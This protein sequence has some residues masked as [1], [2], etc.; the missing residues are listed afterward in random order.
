MDTKFLNKMRQHHQRNEAKAPKFLNEANFHKM[1]YGKNIFRLLT[2]K[3]DPESVGVLNFKHHSGKF[4]F[5]ISEGTFSLNCA[6]KLHGG[7]CPMCALHAELDRE[8]DP[9]AKKCNSKPSYFF[10]AV[11]YDVDDKGKK[12]PSSGRVGILTAPSTVYSQI[13]K[14][15]FNAAEDDIDILDPTSGR[16][17][18]ITKTKTGNRT[19]YFVQPAMRSTKDVIAL[20]AKTIDCNVFNK[21][22][23]WN[24]SLE[25]L[26]E[27]AKDLM[28]ELGIQTPDDADVAYGNSIQ[29]TEADSEEPE[30]E[31]T[32]EE[33][34]EATF[35]TEDQEEPEEETSNIAV[36][37]A[38]VSIRERMAAFKKNNKR[39]KSA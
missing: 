24:E 34:D 12:D 25:V 29:R 36:P 7:S 27:E 16:D 21:C 28:D 37:K 13:M 23:S 35:E 31:G 22:K 8:D 1:A 33:S 14:A 2:H 6:Q 30:E 3:N 17:I 20:K 19:E 26:T 18:I 5:G 39:T 15:V 10:N 11:A 38:N 9:L 4:G 32:P